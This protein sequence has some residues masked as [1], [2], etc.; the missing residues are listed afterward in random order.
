M[1][2]SLLKAGI[3]IHAARKIPYHVAVT[4]RKSK[5]GWYKLNTDGA[6]KECG[7]AARGGVIRNQ[8]GK[9][10]WGFY[11][12]YGTC[13][14][15]E[16]EL[17]AVATGLRLCW[18][19]NINK[20]WVEVDSKAAMLLCIQ[21]DKGPWEVQYILESIHQSVNKM[22]T[23]FSHI[24][25]EGNK[26]AD[27]FANRGYNEKCFKMLQGSELQ[28]VVRGL[29]RMDKMSMASIRLVERMT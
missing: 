7:Q 6:L 19:K 23:Q 18:Q 28:G 22:E 10:S 5:E 20:V 2:E 27:W 21:Q 29:I 8:L 1:L 25:R 11:D 9:I 24:W 13:S 16:A 17:K 26:V 4:W 15:L 14:I 12:F 3:L